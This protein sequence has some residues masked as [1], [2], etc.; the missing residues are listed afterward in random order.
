MKKI[1]MDTIVLDPNPVLRQKCEMVSFP[2][3]EDDKKIMNSLLKYVRD[4][5]DEE[6]AEKEN[7]QPAVGI[8]APQ[9]GVLKQMTAIVVDIEQKDGSF[10]TVEYALINPKIISHSVKQTALKYGEGCLSIRET[11]EG[12]VPRH[13]RIR[14]QAYDMIQ[15]KNIDFRVKDYLAIILQHEIDHLNGVLFYDHINQENP[16]FDQDIEIID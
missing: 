3:Q 2:L 11:H 8:A 16:W 5:R 15:E 6:L 13:K 10:K 1:N 4:S 7:L 12:I 14:I 9:I